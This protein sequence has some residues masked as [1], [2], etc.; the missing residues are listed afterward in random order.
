MLG[1]DPRNVTMETPEAFGVNH[2]IADE[3]SS[4]DNLGDFMRR[5]L[6]V[7]MWSIYS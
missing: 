3:M 4:S 2:V 6:F 1:P 5:I 7:G